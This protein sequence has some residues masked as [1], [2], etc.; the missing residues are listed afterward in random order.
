[1]SNTMSVDLLVLLQK[2]D[3]HIPI[4][5]TEGISVYKEILSLV[6]PTTKTG[7]VPSTSTY[8]LYRC[9]SAMDD[10]PRSGIIHSANNAQYTLCG[11]WIDANYYI[12]TTGTQG[13]INCKN[14]IRIERKRLQK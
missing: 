10:R 12:L 4:T 9:F 6:E 3:K 2:L 1:M 8:T 7:F 5:D 14:C 13:E 11:V